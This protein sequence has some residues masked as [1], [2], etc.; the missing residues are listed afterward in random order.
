MFQF[1]TDAAQEIEIV[2]TIDPAVQGSD[3]DKAAYLRTRDESLLQTEG[4]TRFVVRALTPSQREAAEVAAGVYKRSELGRQ[5]WLAQP[6]DPTERARWQHKL[7]EDE[8]E[9]LGSYE[10]YLARVYR[11][12]MRAGLVRVVGHDGDPLELVD[13]IRPDH[14]RQLLCSELVAH[15]QTLSTLPPEGK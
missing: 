13:R 4:A 2:S 8:R 14:H 7:P 10:G 3:D 5:L 12:M 9:A 11:E 1:A 6:D 15:I